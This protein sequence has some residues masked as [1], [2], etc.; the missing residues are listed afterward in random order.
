MTRIVEVC[1]MDATVK[2]YTFS[3][4]KE[5]SAFA[6]AVIDFP[7]VYFTRLE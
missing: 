6:D 5:A 3:T 4:F 2:A 7:D 1:R